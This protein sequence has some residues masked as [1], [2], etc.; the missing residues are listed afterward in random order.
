MSRVTLGRTRYQTFQLQL[1]LKLLVVF[2]HAFFTAKMYLL[3]I[4]NYKTKQALKIKIIISI[5][6]YYH[7]L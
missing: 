2:G 6:K 1:W 4:Y 3:R 5:M 7:S